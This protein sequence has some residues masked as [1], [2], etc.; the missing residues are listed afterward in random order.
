[1]VKATLRTDKCW[2][3]FIRSPC[4][5]HLLELAILS[6]SDAGSRPSSCS[7]SAG[8]DRDVSGK[9]KRKVAGIVNRS[10]T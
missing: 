5:G 1:M 3:S 10:D 7:P 9:V 8:A 6:L 4:A 2:H